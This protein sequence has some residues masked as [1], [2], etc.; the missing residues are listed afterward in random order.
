MLHFGRWKLISILVIILMGVM[1]TIPNLVPKDERY[2]QN[3]ITGEDEAIDI[4][5]WIPSRTI[6][7]GLDLQGGSHLVFEA[8]MEEV[9]INLLEAL[10]SDATQ[11][12]R[13]E[14]G[15][16][17]RPAVVVGEEVVVTLSRPEDRGDAMTRLNELSNP[18]DANS[19][20]GP[21]TLRITEDPIDDRLIRLVITDEQYEA[22]QTRTITQSIEVV[23]NRLDGMGTVDPTIARQGDKRLL[24]QVPGAEDPSVII[25]LVGAEAMM[26]F[27]LVDE[28]IDAGINGDARL[29]P[30]RS[31]YPMAGTNGTQFLVVHSRTRITGENLTNAN[32]VASHPSFTG[33]VVGFRFDTQGAIAFGEMTRANRGRRFAVILDNEIITAPTINGAIL[34]GS[35]VIGGNYTFESAQELVI[36][37]NAGA[38]PATLT[39]VEQRTITATLGHDQIEQGQLAIVV[40][41]AAVIIFMLAAYG[42][43]GV[44]STIA[45]LVNVVLILGGLSWLGQTLTLPGI[46]GI[47]LTIGMAVDANVLIYERIREESRNGRTPTNAIQSGYE[48]ALAAILDANITTLIAAGVLFMMGAGPVRGFAITL[49]IG[50]ITSVFTAFMFSRLLAVIWL[51]ATKPKTLPL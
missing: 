43:F 31:T 39:P 9:K 38:L 51:R 36:L 41:F 15:I 49:G 46:A 33:P 16:L 13:R 7:L 19:L 47:I 5:K 6:N 3:P 21:E 35:G 24:V 18:V 40:G 25:D 37:L 8:D 10:R 34:D 42:V 50:I 17:I 32:V 22:I 4:W 30:G 20:G 27:H 23:R 28:T 14:P 44:F 1:Y 11:I 12:M 29:P 2:V 26:S 48:R 45:L